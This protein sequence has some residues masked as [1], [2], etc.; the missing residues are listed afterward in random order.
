MT[1]IPKILM[2]DEIIN[3][4]GQIDDL[5]GDNQN[6]ESD[7]FVPLAEALS[8]NKDESKEISD[9]KKSVSYQD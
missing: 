2:L 7:D 6:E 8:I 9:E 5:L 3:S 4:F 1:M